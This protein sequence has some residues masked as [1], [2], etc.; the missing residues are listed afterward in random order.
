MKEY[1]D[2]RFNMSK[3]YRYY[4]AEKRRPVF[5][6]YVCR[7]TSPHEGRDRCKWFTKVSAYSIERL[8][9]VLDTYYESI[10]SL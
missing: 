4:F 7:V 8:K 1:P 6:G 2:I 3:P 10:H 9:R 5:K